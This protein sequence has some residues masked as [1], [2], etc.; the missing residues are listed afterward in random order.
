MRYLSCS[1]PTPKVPTLWQDIPWGGIIAFEMAK[2]LKS[3]GK[4]VK[5]LIM[6]DT[7][8]FRAEVRESLNGGGFEQL[9]YRIN[10]RLF[11]FY[12]LWKHP[13]VLM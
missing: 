11:D 9:K 7:Y 6:F 10:K 8:A 13:L 1:N 5:K 2:Q 3:V 12:L 4:T